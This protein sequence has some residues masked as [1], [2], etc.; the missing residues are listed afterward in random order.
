MEE[1]REKNESF[2]K[3]QER[4]YNRRH[5]VREVPSLPDDAAVWVTSGNRP[6]SGRVITAANT[7]RSY[8][9]ETPTGCIRRNQQHLNIVPDSITDVTP[10]NH[11]LATRYR[12]VTRSQTGTEI[13]PP[14]RYQPRRGDVA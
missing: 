13:V 9:V 8:L 14:K 10:P 1:F 3:K 4:D 12:I 6:I 5:R 7:P 2:K 11:A